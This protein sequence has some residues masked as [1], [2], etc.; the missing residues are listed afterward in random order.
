MIFCTAFSTSPSA[1][2]THW[3]QA[4]LYLKAP[5]GV[6]AGDVIEGTIAFSRGLEYKRAYDI[7]LSFA[8]PHAASAPVTQLWRMV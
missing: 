8:P 6:E 1:E 2:P 5:L 7:T 4:S 3:K